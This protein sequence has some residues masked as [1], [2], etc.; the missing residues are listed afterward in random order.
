MNRALLQ[1]LQKISH[2]TNMDKTEVAK[3]F[4]TSLKEKLA[5]RGYRADL[6]I[7]TD[8]KDTSSRFL[9]SIAF[10]PA[11]GHPDE[12]DVMAIVAQAYPTH[13][14]DWE[15][16]EV[17]SDLGIVLIPLAPSTEVVPVQ[18]ISQIPEEFVSIG[19]G[20]YKRAVDTTGQAQEIWTL[21]RTDS[22]LA[23]FRTQDD[24]DVQATEDEFKAGDV[25][26]TPHGPGRILRFDDMGNA[27]VQV[28]NAKRL[29]AKDDMRPYKLEKEKKSLEDYFAQAYGDRDF[30]KSLVDTYSK[31]RK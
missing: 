23:L 29:V 28:G 21:K 5:A 13:D 25:A 14:V 8:A 12:K 7:A 9:A 10:N 16:A 30:A 18:S 6:T 20:I 11:L 24:M 19:A 27:L 17:D 1:R 15:L 4:I 31:N 3:E 2:R 26:N 22:G